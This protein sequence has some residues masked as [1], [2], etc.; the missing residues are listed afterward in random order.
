MDTGLEFTLFPVIE[1]ENLL[2][3]KIIVEDIDVIFRIY[4]DE[5]IMKYFGREKM[6]SYSEAEMKY[7]QLTEDFESRKGIRWAIS[8]KPD[9][10][11]IGS[12]GFWKIMKENFRAEIGYELLPEHWRKGIMTEA[13]RAMI[14]F[15]FEVMKLHSIEANTDPE[16]TA[17]NR[18]LDKLGFKLEGHFRE[19]FCFNGKYLDTYTFSLI[20]EN[21]KERLK[22]GE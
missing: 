2:L 20:N 19:N 10:K 18:M 4:S 8:K 15:G 9:L 1:T 14:K 22:A 6:K 3:R 17:S 5:Q 11:M 16:N 13:L 12:G 21:D 7:S